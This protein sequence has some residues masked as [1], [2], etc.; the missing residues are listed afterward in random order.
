MPGL[1]ENLE[2]AD[3]AIS[4]ELEAARA[5]RAQMKE[6]CDHLDVE[7]PL[8]FELLVL[9][10]QDAI[11]PPTRSVRGGSGIHSAFRARD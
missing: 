5:A 2:K 3:E 8:E 11:N 6:E 10:W 9:G 4:K 7:A 1:Q